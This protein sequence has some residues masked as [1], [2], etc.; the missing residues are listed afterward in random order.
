MGLFSVTTKWEG[1]LEQEVEAHVPRIK[2]AANMALHQCATGMISSLQEHI[3][4]DWLE[5][6]GDPIVYQR[7]T[8]DPDNRGTPLGSEDY[9]FP[10]VRGL[11]LTF[12]YEPKGD[13]ANPTWHTHDGDEIISI[14]QTAKGWTPGWEPDLD[15]RLR[16][17]MP[18]PF[19]NNFV[20]EQRCG[21]LF[22]TFEYGFGGRGYDLIREG[23]ERDLEFPASESKLPSD[24]SYERHYDFR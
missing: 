6:W 23:G 24:P 14:L 18:R 9:M 2:D 3:Q 10:D 16:N 13:H 7:R 5:P 21:V 12:S 8:D 15:R 22:D 11:T 17:I 19:W 1:S 20:E 4:H